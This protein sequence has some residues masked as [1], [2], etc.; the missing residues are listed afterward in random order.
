LDYNFFERLDS[1]KGGGPSGDSAKTGIIAALVL[2][3]GFLLYTYGSTVIE[4]QRNQS[5]KTSLENNLASHQYITELA[6]VED[7]D[8]QLGEVRG[9]QNVLANMY[10]STLNAD[11]AKLA[12]LERISSEVPMGLSVSG[13]QV[14]SRNVSLRGQ[15]I[16]LMTIAQYEHNLRNTGWFDNIVISSIHH[17][18][19]SPLDNFSQSE[20]DPFDDDFG[21]FDGEDGN[22][23]Y[24][25]PP[26]SNNTGFQRYLQRF[27]Y[28]I[29]MTLTDKYF[30]DTWFGEEEHEYADRIPRTNSGDQVFDQLDDQFDNQ[31]FDQ[32]DDQ[33]FN[34]PDQGDIIWEVE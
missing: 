34:L 18:D 3:V 13:I 14:H 8:V 2:G 22:P 1:D 9:A 16:S 31:F 11:T 25:P 20:P 10:W 27:S 15:G 5:L 21:D 23:F 26:Q 17:T 7:L 29:T 6:R 4:Y 24:V 33:F 28:D 30:V 19:L 12:L 32:F